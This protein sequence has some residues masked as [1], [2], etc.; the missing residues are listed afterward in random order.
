MII[1]Q[2]FCSLERETGSLLIDL[3]EIYGFDYGL[4]RLASWEGHLRLERMEGHGWVQDDTALDYSFVSDAMDSLPHDHPMQHF[5]EKIPQWAKDVVR[6]FSVNQLRLLRI[7][8]INPKAQELAASSPVVFW[9]LPECMGDCSTPEL[10]FELTGMQRS[11]IL[12]R[13][14]GDSSKSLLHCLGKLDHLEFSLFDLEC[15]RL[16][17]G[18]RG[19]FE[20]RHFN[21]L[22]WQIL[23][24]LTRRSNWLEYQSL[25]SLVQTSE[26][27][28]ARHRLQEWNR[29]T[30]DVNR[31]ANALGLPDP[32]E[33]LKRLRNNTELRRL[34]D[35]LTARLNR[36]RTV[37]VEARYQKPFPCPPLSG[38]LDIQ[39]ITSVGELLDEGSSMHHCVASYM[40]MIFSG[41][42]YIYKVLSPERATLEIKIL[43][44]GKCRINQLKLACNAKPSVETAARVRFW[45][46]NAS[47]M[48]MKDKIQE[49]QSLATPPTDFHRPFLP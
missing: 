43:P 36:Q 1:G 19:W 34:H 4:I 37:A 26:V 27:S 40:D 12:G 13:A 46:K 22:N 47:N 8:S 31:L 7:L 16:L 24:I 2:E 23:K 44:D 21:A 32:S 45:M 39:P 33:R 38:D 30:A 49:S 20:L 35:V 3:R 9:L 28:V 17:F 41:T 15:L 29:L 5:C 48:R 18:D 10:V 6:P 25:R 11:K 14:L 42:C